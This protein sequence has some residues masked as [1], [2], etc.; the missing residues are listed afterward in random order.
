MTD[1]TKWR[2]YVKEGRQ[3]WQ[4]FP[5]PSTLQTVVEKYLLGLDIVSYNNYLFKKK[6]NLFF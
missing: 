2:L 4:Y 1:L 3:V 5:S 6:S